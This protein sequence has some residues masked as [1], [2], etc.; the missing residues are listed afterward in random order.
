MIST[1]LLSLLTIYSTVCVCNAYTPPSLPSKSP[2]TQPKISTN[3]RRAFINHATSIATGTITTSAL[4]LPRLSN[5]A[6]SS[7]LSLGSPAPSFTLPNSKGQQVTLDS[8]SSSGKWTVL[9]FFPGAFTSGCTLEAR[10]FQEDVD[11][12]HALNSQIVGV[13]V[14]SVDKNSAFCREEKLDF[15]MLTDEV[16]S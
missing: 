6:S 13:S 3:S 14:D 4:F 11:K 10:K 15:F 8:L 1:Q 12:Y 2:L 16:S 5:A 7:P 9:Y